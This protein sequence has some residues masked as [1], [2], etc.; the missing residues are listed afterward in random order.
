MLPFMINEAPHIS[1]LILSQD[2]AQ[3]LRFNI[4]YLI[5]TLPG[6]HFREIK[7]RM[8]M[9][10]G[11][12]LF[13]LNHLKKMGMIR[14]SNDGQYRR[15]Y[16]S[17]EIDNRDERIIELSRRKN[18][19]KILT[20]LVE[21]GTIQYSD[22]V[23]ELNLS[24]STVSFHLKKLLENNIIVKYTMGRKSY[25]SLYDPLLIKDVV[26]KYNLVIF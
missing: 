8:S 20:M 6:I 5:Y 16:T 10:T 13:H 26:T 14:I 25:Y 17:R 9:G 23:G 11:H 18:I 24:L 2:N 3:R 4:F 19:S 15:Y 12:L 21:K 1:S 22:L 7:R